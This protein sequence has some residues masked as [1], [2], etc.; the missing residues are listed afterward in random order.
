MTNKKSL[1]DIENVSKGYGEGIITWALRSVNLTI[2]P[3]E[4]TAIVGA[5]GSGKSTLLNLIGALDKPTFGRVRVDGKDT[6]ILNE[7]GLAELRSGTIGFVFQFHYLLKEFSILD[8]ALM[9]LMMRNH[10][11]TRDEIQWVHKLFARV[12]LDQQ[13]HCRPSQLSGG[14]Q[15]RAAIVRALANKPKLILADEPTG[16][17]DRQN[18]TMVFDLL[19]EINAQLGI[20]F[21]LVTHDDRLAERAR[22]VIVI[23]D[24]TVAADY[25]VETVSS[26]G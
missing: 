1:V 5:S 9:P 24:G 14:Q 11:A 19:T 23:E 21:V 18:G 7:E 4:F 22:R 20:A 2:T 15:Q 16:N 13:K 3:G 17:L 6:A 10:G 25:D 8:N 26:A 12:G